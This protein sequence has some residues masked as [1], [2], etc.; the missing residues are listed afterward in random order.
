M[1]LRALARRACAAQRHRACAK[2]AALAGPD[3]RVDSNIHANREIGES[4]RGFGPCL[5]TGDH[6]DLFDRARLSRKVCKHD[7]YTPGVARCE[8]DNAARTPA[9]SETRIPAHYSKIINKVKDGAL[10]AFTLNTNIGTCVGEAQCGR[11]ADTHDVQIA[12][13]GPKCPIA[14]AH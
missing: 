8:F 13:N 10:V 9:L 11:C 2:R 14:I 6:H 12:Y 4:N 5:V 1:N 7:F 3:A